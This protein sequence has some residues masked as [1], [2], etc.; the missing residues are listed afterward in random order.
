MRNMLRNRT[1]DG[2]GR[3][4]SRGQTY[5]ALA[6]IA[7]GMVITGLILPFAI[8][9]RSSDSTSTDTRVT[10]I[11]EDL[12]EDT[13]GVPNGESATPGTD[14]GGNTSPS[15]TRSGSGSGG[16]S[17]STSGT[18]PVA[19]S[20]PA[21]TALPPI[22]VGFTILDVGT[23]GRAGIAVLISPEQQERAWRA[24]VKEVN[25]KNL[26]GRKIEPAFAT[27]DA[28][29]EDSQNAA[30]LTL[31]EDHKVFAVLGGF[32]YAAPNSCVVK[33]HTTPLVSNMG[34]NPDSYYTQTADRLIT[35]TARSSRMFKNAVAVLDSVQALQGKKIGI[36]RSDANDPSGEATG[37][38]EQAL[39]ATGHEVVHTSRLPA[40]PA[41]DSQIPVEVNRMRQ[42]GA[43]VVFL[44][45]GSTS[46]TGFVQTA[47]AQTY[48]PRYITTDWGAMFNT[49]SSANMPASYE[50]TLT[51]TNARESEWRAN[52]PPP[53]LANECKETYE[54]NSGTKLAERGTN[55]HTLTLIYCDLVRAFV[56]G[57]RAGGAATTK[58]QFPA[59]MGRV[60]A[61]Q[62]ASWGDGAFRPGK[63]DGGDWVILQRWRADCKCFHPV[64][65]FRPPKA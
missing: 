16:A 57:M 41:S 31:T 63:S 58:E 8:G 19:G 64:G 23:V 54:R 45:A 61:M 62:W 28:L 32:N 55:E 35:A 34:S 10:G 11:G 2:G 1:A 56:A 53:A 33:Q 12:G 37:H 39:R 22:K 47:D 44:L 20:A 40:P 49:T 46:S 43:E 17:A 7:A 9:E 51:V 29:N 36:V 13:A 59:A 25:D 21:G 4:R 52:R 18:E 38:L 50:G 5:A 24:Y 27:F 60:G 14:A 15:G 30:C 42:S 65:D 6:G 26:I 3:L 48:R